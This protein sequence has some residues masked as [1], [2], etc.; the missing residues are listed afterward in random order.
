MRSQYNQINCQVA[1][2]YAQ[3]EGDIS[4]CFF[5]QLLMFDAI[6]DIGRH[7]GRHLGLSRMPK[8]ERVRWL[9]IDTDLRGDNVHD[10]QKTLVTTGQADCV[11]ESGF[12]ARRKISRVQNVAK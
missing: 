12:R 11:G 7:Q 9:R 6:E 2:Q 1:Y 5:D 10:G 3:Y 4:L 8:K